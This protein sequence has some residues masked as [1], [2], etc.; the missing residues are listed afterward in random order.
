MTAPQPAARSTRLT[1][2]LALLR[3]CTPA[4]RELLAGRAGTKV[5]Y[6]YHLAGCTRTPRASLAVKLV[7]ASDWMH[8]RSRGRVP[9]I[10]MHELVTMCDEDCKL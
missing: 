10:T 2:L 6:L 1:P 8:K 4:E 9:A 3:A 7:S 5:S